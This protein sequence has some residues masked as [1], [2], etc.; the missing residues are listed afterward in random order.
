MFDRAKQVDV[1]LPVDP[2]HLNLE[3][4]INFIHQA[5]INQSDDEEILLMFQEAAAGNPECIHRV[6]NRLRDILTQHQVITENISTNEVVEKAYSTL[7]GLGKIQGL[8]YDDEIDEIRINPNGNVFIS[9]RGKNLPTDIKMT[10]KEVKSL[11]E[12]LIPYTD[13]GSSLNESTPKLE[14]V[15]P[16]GMRVTA[17]CSPIVNGYGLAIRKHGNI[18]L[19]AESLKQ[20]KTMD[21]TIWA[22]LKIL[23][24]G[25]RNIIIS[26]G[27]NTGK[28][29]LLKLL[30]GEYAPYLSI[31]VLDLD[32]E[33]HVSKIYPER[34]IWELEAHPEIDV[35]MN[36]LFV[37]ILR[38]TP[39]VVVVGEFR[40][41]GEAKEAIRAC[42]R[43]HT[44]LATAHFS[45]PEEA[46]QGTAMMMLEEGMSLDI[47]NAQLRVAQAF[48][49]IVQMIADTS[50]GIKK[51][52]SITE[53]VVSGREI[54]YNTI[55]KW[56]PAGADFMGEGQ[57]IV[58]NPMSEKCIK[59]MGVY[60]VTEEDL[61]GIFTER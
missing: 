56:Q 11:I 53:V 18:I 5:V 44:G 51:I 25:R 4:T 45:E 54:K 36:S 60:N 40:G 57:W 7:W 15:R 50:R 1:T 6:K 30:I 61:R 24:K 19:S 20:M 13:R 39:D 32:N 42:T 34:D 22:I 8:Y 58:V 21:D 41:I 33:L 43:G 31:R 28:T 29:T 9:Q 48:Q 16:D 55:A 2:K 47:Q 10:Q 17:L 23:I 26:G 37:S 38:L 14:L 12:R 49:F 59:D 46:I 35:D 3:Q 27:V 52:V